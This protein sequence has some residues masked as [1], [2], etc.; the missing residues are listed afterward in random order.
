MKATLSKE[1]QQAIRKCLTK[2]TV[3]L[4][5]D[6]GFGKTIVMLEVYKR[7]RKR[8]AIDTLLVVASRKIGR[9]VWMKEITKW[10]YDF[11]VTALSGANVEVREDRLLNYSIALN[12][13]ND[14]SVVIISYDLIPWLF[15][16]MTRQKKVVNL[17][18][19]MLVLDESS[20]FK[21]TKSK[22]WRALRKMLDMFTCRFIL[23]GTPTPNS[24]E[25][26][27]AQIYILD[28]GKRLKTKTNFMAMYFIPC[29]YMNYDVR[30]RKGAKDDIYKEIKDIV[31]RFDSSSLNL[32]SLEVRDVTFEMSKSSQRVHDK[33]KKDLYALL[34]GAEINAPNA[35]AAMT[36]MRQIAGGAVYVE[37]DDW[38]GLTS[39][40]VSDFEIEEGRCYKTIDNNKVELLKSLI[41]ELQGKPCLVA[42]EFNHEKARLKKAFPKA[43]FFESGATDNE[44]ANIE[45]L[46]NAGKIDLLFGH[47]A[48]IGHGLN[49]QDAEDACVIFFSLN[50]NYDNYYQFIKRVWRQGRKGTVLVY[51]L[52]ALDSIDGKVIK[53]LANKGKSQTDF[54]NLLKKER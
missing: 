52:V 34:D 17:G 22:R 36:K 13:Y 28:K 14:P 50:Y 45:A 9:L 51:R 6:P 43:R 33:V 15:D 4:F 29:G 23:T 19:T 37:D 10:R 7:L 53:N 42:Y 47:P 24:L 18:R 2:H 40:K 30:P 8:D 48:S 5:A 25:D 38:S 32:P 16:F 35:G 44:A 46:W 12:E 31:M 26:L 39:S 3:G 27:Y 54:L 1:Q 49:L 11:N 41:E 20:K 21:S